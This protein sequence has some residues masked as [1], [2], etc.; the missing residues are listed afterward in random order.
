MINDFRE[1]STHIKE[2]YIWIIFG[3]ILIALETIHSHKIMHRDLKP[4]NVFVSFTDK[5]PL[6]IYCVLGDFGLA[7][8][9]ANS[10]AMANT[11]C[12]TFNYMPPELI[13]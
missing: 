12:G 10:F 7:R 5:Y 11:V 9:M 3:Q 6:Q 13:H 8:S 2:D 4:G 1:K